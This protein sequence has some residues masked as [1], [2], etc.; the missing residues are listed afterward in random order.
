MTGTTSNIIAMRVADAVSRGTKMNRRLIHSLLTAACAVA[1]L[2]LAP[3]GQATA[4]S[5]TR[6]AGDLDVALGT[7]GT[8]IPVSDRRRDRCRIVD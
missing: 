2:S 8:V 7:K 6:P 1:P 5:V 3:A 4:Q